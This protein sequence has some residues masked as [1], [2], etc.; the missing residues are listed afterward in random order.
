[1]QPKKKRKI[2]RK[3]EKKIVLEN[4]RKVIGNSR[5]GLMVVQCQN[6]N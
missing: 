5:H 6:N 4:I 3:M 1:M 2:R